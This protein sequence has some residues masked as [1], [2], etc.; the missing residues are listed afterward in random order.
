[1]TTE[2]STGFLTLVAAAAINA[3]I[4]VKIDANGKADIA[5]TT[6]AAVGVT[7]HKVAS[8]DPVTVKLFTGPGTFLCTAGG[9]ITRGNQVFPTTAGK[10]LATGTTALNLVANEAATAD[11]D[12][13]E[14]SMVMKGA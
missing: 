4:R 8:G 6:D 2:N 1:M 5:S 11:G 13:I 3:H 9:A 7:Q 10:V 12:V 14:C